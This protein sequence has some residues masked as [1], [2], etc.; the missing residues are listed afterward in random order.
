MNS[1][2]EMSCLLN[3]LLAVD[4]LRGGQL[5]KWRTIKMHCTL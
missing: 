2:Y 5:R 1:V 3:D 4:S